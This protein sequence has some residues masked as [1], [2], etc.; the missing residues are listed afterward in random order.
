MVAKNASKIPIRVVREDAKDRMLW[1]QFSAGADG[2]VRRHMKT[3]MT[4]DIAPAGDNRVVAGCDCIQALIRSCGLLTR[5]D[6]SAR[7]CGFVMCCVAVEI[8]SRD[9]YPVIRCSL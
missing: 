6:S 9:L 8:E 3:K 4:F 5:R 1:L 2:I 7:L